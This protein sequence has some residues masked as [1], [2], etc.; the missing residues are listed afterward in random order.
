MAVEVVQ[1]D[2]RQRSREGLMAQLEDITYTALRKWSANI[3]KKINSAPSIYE[4][5]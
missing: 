3:A 4:E 2:R 5:P 1:V